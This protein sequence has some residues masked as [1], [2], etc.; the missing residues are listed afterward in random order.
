FYY[1]PKLLGEVRVE[2]AVEFALKGASGCIAD[3][4]DALKTAAGREGSVGTADSENVQCIHP[5]QERKIESRDLQTWVL[6]ADIENYVRGV[7]N[8]LDEYILKIT[9]RS[10]KAGAL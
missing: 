6:D 2:P 4:L 10:T 8:E 1:W 5:A 9:R 3:I 7:V